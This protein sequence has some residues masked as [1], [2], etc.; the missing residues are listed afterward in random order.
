MPNKKQSARLVSPEDFWKGKTPCWEIAHCPE[1]IQAD[2]PAPRHREYACWE[3]GGTY[4]KCDEWGT[5]GRDT[6]IC[7][8][9]EVYIRWGEGK[10]IELRLLGHGIK[11][12]SN[13]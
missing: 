3:I 5:L 10:R 12:L 9:C 6:S 11:L 1:P 13:L 4:C 8:I 7:L 2:C